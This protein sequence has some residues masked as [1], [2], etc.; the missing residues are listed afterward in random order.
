MVSERCGRSSSSSSSSSSFSAENLASGSAEEDQTAD[1]PQA[2]RSTMATGTTP[3]DAVPS[4][5]PSASGSASSPSAPGRPGSFISYITTEEVPDDGGASSSGGSS[6]DRKDYNNASRNPPSM[7][8]SIRA[9]VYDGGLRYHAFRDGK[10]AFPN[11]EIEQNRDDMKHTMTRKLCHDR[12]FYAPVEDALRK[13]GQCLDLGTGTGIWV[14]EMGDAYPATSFTGIDLSPIQPNYVPENVHFFIDDF[15]EEW[16]DPEDKFDYIHVRH[17]L[18]SVRDRGALLGR[19]FKHLKPG[20][21]VEFQE[22]HYVPHC[23]DGSM[24]PETPYA[25]R[26]FMSYLEQGMRALG[27]DLNAITSLRA[28]LAASGFE[29]IQQVTHKCPIGVWPRDKRLRLCGHFMRTAT[30]DGLRG[31]SRRPFGTGLR[32]TQLQIEMFLVDVRKAVMDSRFHVYFPFHVIYA[33]KP[34]G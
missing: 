26:D 32:W 3:A 14:I 23:D 24:T 6:R 15:E 13:G 5:V 8:S 27:S 1:P 12:L 4:P 19:I 7:T 20:G 17:T 21:Y 18:H 31:L 29:D 34:S 11:D 22:M 2:E 25:F 33:R 9:H 28:E 10:Y 16:V 30:M